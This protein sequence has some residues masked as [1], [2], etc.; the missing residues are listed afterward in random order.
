MK[1]Y[2]ES[3]KYQVSSISFVIMLQV[4]MRHANSD[5][6]TLNAKNVFSFTHAN[7]DYLT[8]VV[9]FNEAFNDL[10]NC[11]KA[12]EIEF[13][14]ILESIAEFQVNLDTKPHNIE[15]KTCHVLIL[16]TYS[17]DYVPRICFD[18]S[19]KKWF[20]AAEL[21]IQRWPLRHVTLP[22]QPFVTND[23]VPT[24]SSFGN[25]IERYWVNSDGAAILVDE[26]TPLFSSFNDSG[27]GKLCFEAK[28]EHPFINTDQKLPGLNVQLCKSENV[29]LVHQYVSR[30]VLEKSSG[31]P[32]SR[33]FKS[34]IWS[35]WARY[36]VDINQ[37]K[38][39]E[40]AE[41]IIQNGFSNSQIE[42]DDMFSTFYG[43]FDFTPEKFPNPSQMIK[44]LKSKGFRVTVW[45][46]PF[47][48]LDS[49]AFKTGTDKSYWLH[50]KRKKVPAL[51][52][53]WQGIGAILDVSNSDAVTWFVKR[54]EDMRRNYGIDSFK[55]DAGEVTYLPYSYGPKVDWEDPCS[56]T[57][58]YVSAVSGLGDMIEVNIMHF[59]IQC[60]I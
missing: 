31:Y 19:E 36:K 29:K 42:I 30:S 38:V 24:N 25:V 27:D 49:P 55:F 35:T 2:K 48:N 26:T 50:D 4:C 47:A 34:P 10:D 23:I 58:L 53:W 43:E 9:D 32:D 12:S 6:F 59:F 14:K 15:D 33:M 16:Q 21:Q 18:L 28:F 57:R 45:I 22:M 17:K 13:C 20:G 7:N 46:T 51:L 54:L 52:K 8:G 1:I 41:E 3:R 11:K 37:E 5:D 40:Y 60:H 44:K 56:Y 39:L